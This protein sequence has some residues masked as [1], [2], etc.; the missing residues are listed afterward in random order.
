VSA[1]REAILAAEN[2]PTAASSR[3]TPELAAA[4]QSLPYSLVVHTYSNLSMRAFVEQAGFEPGA[5]ISVHA[6]LAQSGI[7]LGQHAYAWT[8]VTRPDGSTSTLVLTEH[9]TV[10]YAGSFTATMP[11][12]YR[13]RVRARGTTYG[14]EPF[15][16]EKTLT[17]AV[18]RGGNSTGAA[19]GSGA[20]GGTDASICDLLRCL[21]HSDV[22]IN[23]S[24]EE[25]LRALG[26][27]LAAARK[28]VEQFCRGR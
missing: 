20:A 15:T 2:A 10:Q 6:S 19:G 8:D 22:I 12:V 3:G 18:W 5:S 9:E 11:G 14:G 23:A 21:L 24:V 27:D 13:A 16:R 1:R 26:I 4:A 25:R 28:C 7:P 17:A